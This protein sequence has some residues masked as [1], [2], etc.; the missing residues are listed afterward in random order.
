[1]TALSLF[2]MLRVTQEIIC[3][4][5]PSFGGF[6][7]KSK[8]IFLILSVFWFNDMALAQS[9]KDFYSALTRACYARAE[10]LKINNSTQSWVCHYTQTGGVSIIKVDQNGQQKRKNVEE[11]LVKDNTPYIVNYDQTY[12]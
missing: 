2:A 5:H 1:L 9:S 4:L 12:E 8:Y 7:K 3:T 6:V 11:K 10:E